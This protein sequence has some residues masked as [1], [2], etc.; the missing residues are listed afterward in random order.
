MNPLSRS[1]QTC[2][3]IKDSKRRLRDSERKKKEKEKKKERAE[4]TE[5]DRK[6]QS[7]SEDRSDKRQ[8]GKTPRR[9][10]EDRKKRDGE[11]QSMRERERERERERSGCLFSFVFSTLLLTETL[12]TMYTLLQ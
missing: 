11:M 8:V 3:R 5:N 10:H 4:Q 1:Q 9:C 7:N 6:M 12:Q 2:T